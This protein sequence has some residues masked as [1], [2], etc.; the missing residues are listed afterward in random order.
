MGHPIAKAQK[1]DFEVKL[2][3]NRVRQSHGY[4]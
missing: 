1:F 2:L 4:S 3:L